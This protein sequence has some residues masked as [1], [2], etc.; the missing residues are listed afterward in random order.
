M[1]MSRPVKVMFVCIHNSC[2][3]QMA[4]AFARHSSPDALAPSSGGTTLADEVDPIAVRVMAEKGID[5][6]RA[7]PRLA[8]PETLGASDLI[9]HMGCGSEAMC[10]FVPGVP[11]ENWGIEDPKG[12]GVEEYRRVRDLIEAKVLDLAQRARTS[13]IVQNTMEFKL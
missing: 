4:E 1:P 5:I 7:R 6:S 10:P 3:S 9:V 12:K 8:T 11:S 13:H 2:R